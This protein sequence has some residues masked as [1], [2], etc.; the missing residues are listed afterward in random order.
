ML[1]EILRW[2]PLAL[3]ILLYLA[4]LELNKNSLWGWALA[5]ILFGLYIFLFVKFL[6]SHSFGIKLAG[7]AGLLITLTAVFLLSWPPTKP[8]PAVDVKNPKVTEVLKLQDGAI[9]GVYTEDGKVAVYAGIPYAAPP[10]GELRWKEPQPAQPW[11][12]VRACDTFAS[13]SMQPTNLPIYNS[14]AQIIGYHD[15][16]ISLTD[17]WVAPV[18]ED[19]LYVNVWKPATARE[20]D[21]LPVIV[22]IHGGSLQ[23]GQP[24]YSDYAGAALAEHGAIVVNMGYRLGVFGF[25]ADEEL[26]AESPNGTTGN[27][28]LLDQI[29]ALRWVQANIAAFGGDPDNVTVAGESAGSACVSALLTSPLSSGLFRR[30]VLESSTVSAAEPAHSFRLFDAAIASGRE[31]K[32]RYQADSIDE[33]RALPADKLVQEANT[34][35]HITIDG[36]VLPKTPYEAYLDGTAMNVPLLHGFN[37]HEGA[38]FIIFSN[39]DLKNYEEKVRRSF[40][41]YA[42][43][44]LSLYP[45]STDAQAR[46][47]WEQIYSAILFSYG[48]YCLTRQAIRQGAPVYEY[49]F[50]KENGRL[51]AWHSGEEVYLYG[52]IPADSAL[53]TAADRTLSEQMVQYFVNFAAS[54]NPN[55][56]TDQADGS[57]LP[58]W[59]SLTSAE[60]IFELNENPGVIPEPYLELYRI[61]DRMHGFTE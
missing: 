12:G 19:A 5:L 41:E 46:E 15:Y 47:N 44:V 25:L 14:L 1:R 35:H 43:E 2:I 10:V 42:D 24:W 56:P 54:G 36:Y 11:E 58:E 8:V 59:K 26:A 55:I 30:A 61:L 7:F 3:F 6:S 39:A 52:N 29:Q 57:P 50:T 17:N 28:G 37:A 20:G 18:S 4:V 27:Y 53:Y 60:E 34:Q 13:M 9:T 23:T 22:Y 49:F 31:L 38:A 40:G 16:R 32:T 21:K 51:G 48:H 33:L 45:A